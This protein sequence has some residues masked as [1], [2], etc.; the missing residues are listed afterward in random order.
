MD[1]SD[2]QKTILTKAYYI[3]ALLLSL[4]AATSA[5]SARERAGTTES[6]LYFVCKYCSFG[7]CLVGVKEPDTGYWV[8]LSCNKK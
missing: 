3:L 2:G 5:T 6:T 8:E 7:Q 4:L 1:S